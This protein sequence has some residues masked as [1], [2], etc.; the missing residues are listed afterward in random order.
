[1]KKLHKI[2]NLNNK[3][4][5]IGLGMI[6]EL[7]IMPEKEFLEYVRQN[8]VASDILALQVMK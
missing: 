8:A 3:H 1:M 2:Y 6:G 5:N 4:Q 7:L